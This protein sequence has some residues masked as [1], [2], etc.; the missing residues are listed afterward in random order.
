[1]T[2]VLSEILANCS[3]ISSTEVNTR[4]ITYIFEEVL[5]T[6]TS[7]SSIELAQQSKEQTIR[8][9]SSA[10]RIL[11]FLMSFLTNKSVFKVII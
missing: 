7:Y 11:E 3:F 9:T 2:A 5:T 1:V 6:L 10:F 8:R 4:D